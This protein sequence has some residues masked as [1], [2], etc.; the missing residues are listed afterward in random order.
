MGKIKR[1]LRNYRINRAIAK[2]QKEQIKK[3][4]K[5]YNRLDI[6]LDELKRDLENDSII[7][8]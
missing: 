6:N 2:I 7:F 8:L 1:K 3:K 5:T 4:N